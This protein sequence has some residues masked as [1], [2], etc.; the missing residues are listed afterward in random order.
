MVLKKEGK[1]RTNSPPLPPNVETGVRSCVSKLRILSQAIL[2]TSFRNFG[3]CSSSD[4]EYNLIY[5]LYVIYY[6]WYPLCYMICFI[7]CIVYILTTF[8]E[9]LYTISSSLFLVLL[10]YIY[11]YIFCVISSFVRFGLPLGVLVWELHGNCTGGG[12]NLCLSVLEL[13]QFSYVC[14]MTLIMV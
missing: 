11:I 4:Q 5:L 8:L 2:L 12:M 7:D 10:V 3:D 6:A 14:V 1:G 13:L 9:L